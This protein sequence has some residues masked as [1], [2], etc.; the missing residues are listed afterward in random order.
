MSAAF[1]W[2]QPAFQIPPCCTP[3][4]HTPPAGSCIALQ[5]SVGCS[6]SFASDVLVSSCFHFF[7]SFVDHVAWWQ[8]AVQ[9]SP[10][11]NARGLHGHAL[12]PSGQSLSFVQVH[13][14]LI[15]ALSFTPA[16]VLVHTLFS[17]SGWAPSSGPLAP[18]AVACQHSR[19]LHLWHRLMK[20]VVVPFF[21]HSG[22]PAL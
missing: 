15:H 14:G 17:K 12:P 2:E 5:C 3:S 13:K 20:L 4:P 7:F 18:M 1:A 10:P 22:R 21:F 19:H 8:Q 16:P 9:C 11:M 6:L